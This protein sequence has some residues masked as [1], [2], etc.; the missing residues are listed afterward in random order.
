MRILSTKCHPKCY[1]VLDNI[2]KAYLFYNHTYTELNKTLGSPKKINGDFYGSL[3]QLQFQGEK[4][5]AL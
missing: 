1:L 5:V 4:R 3:N 2:T